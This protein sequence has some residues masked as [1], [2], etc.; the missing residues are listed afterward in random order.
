MTSFVYNSPYHIPECNY[1]IDALTRIAK[2]Q[3]DHGMLVCACR[4]R[5]RTMMLNSDDC[6]FV[7]LF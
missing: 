6:S 3:G 7:L 2:N 1:V 4:F 5:F